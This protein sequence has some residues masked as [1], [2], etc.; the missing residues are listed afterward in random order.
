MSSA[1]GCAACQFHHIR[2]LSHDEGFP[3]I[4]KVQIK[5]KEKKNTKCT[6][7]PFWGDD[8]IYQHLPKL[9][10]ITV[11]NINAF[12]DLM[13]ELTHV[14]ASCVLSRLLVKQLML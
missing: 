6:H 10:Q 13:L 8:I 1:D 2:V 5:I 9:L 4:S 3:L 7:V 12:S 11:I 14:S